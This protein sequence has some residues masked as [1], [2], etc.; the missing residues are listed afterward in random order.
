MD[1]WR[2]WMDWPVQKSWVCET[3]MRYSGLTWGLSHA[4]CRCNTCH[5]QYTMRDKDDNVVDM[6]ISLLK[7]EYKKPAIEGY[8][9]YQKP[10]SEFSDKD[11]DSLLKDKV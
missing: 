11:W 4:V 8:K 6:P 10:I 5:T 1:Y 7:D 3:C 9:K 2:G